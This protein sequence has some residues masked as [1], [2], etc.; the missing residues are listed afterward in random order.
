MFAR[1][2]P[3][4]PTVRARLQSRRDHAAAGLKMTGKRV[5][6]MPVD[7]AEVDAGWPNLEL[8]ARLNPIHLLMLVTLKLQTGK[9][10]PATKDLRAIVRDML[11][12]AKVATLRMGPVTF[13]LS[14]DRVS[15]YGENVRVTR[16]LRVDFQHPEEKF[17]PAP[18]KR[19]V[20]MER[21]MTLLTEQ[22][23][24]AETRAVGPLFEQAPAAVRLATNLKLLN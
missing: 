13:R 17:V 24:A 14:E 21:V 8:D 2:P 11:D 23:K 16:C 6:V 5:V 10:L 19:G 15:I 9:A 1:K 18:R 7:T 20:N 3:M 22:P 4:L 12:A